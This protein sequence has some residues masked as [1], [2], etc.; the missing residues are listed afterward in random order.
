M[1]WTRILATAIIV[2]QSLSASAYVL[3]ASA[4]NEDVKM[5]ELR[6]GIENKSKTRPRR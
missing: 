3:P 5:Q 4:V 6:S 1:K 2:F